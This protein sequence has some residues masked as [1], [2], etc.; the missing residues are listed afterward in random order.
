MRIPNWFHWPFLLQISDD[1]R[2]KLTYDDIRLRTIR[3]AQNL[4]AHGYKTKQ[5]FGVMARNS[6][7]LAPIVFASLSLGCAVSTLDP[8]FA[9]MELLHLLKTTQ[10][11]LMFC[12]LE[13]SDLV[14]ECLNELNNSAKIF[15]FGGSKDGTESAESLFLET[16]KENDFV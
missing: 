8:S 14:R 7:H 11:K 16:N 2:V 9:K 10:P 3:V 5:V 6:Q 13:S 12:E 1:S 15:T 4:Q